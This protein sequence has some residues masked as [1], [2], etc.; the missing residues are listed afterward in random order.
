MN[1]KFS[2]KKMNRLLIGFLSILLIES[3]KIS[4]RGAYMIGYF[5]GFMEEAVWDEY[6]NVWTI[7]YGHTG[8]DVY[9]GQ[10][11]TREEALKLLQ[12]D[13][14]Y[15]ESFVNDKD[16]VPQTLNQAQFD[17]LVSFSYNL[18]PYT[19]PELC[20]GN[21]IEQIAVDIL[22][23]C[24][25]GGVE[26]PGLVKRRKAES[27]LLLYGYTGIS[28]IDEKYDGNPI[29]PP[30]NVK[31]TYTVMTKGG[32]FE[33][34]QDGEVAGKE[35]QKIIGIA[36]K[37][38]SG[39]VK[40]RVHIVGGSWLPY[41]TGYD[42]EDYDNGYAGNGKPI[43]CVEVIHDSIT[44]KYRVSPMNSDFYSWQK[45]SETGGDMD[46]YA[47]SYGKAIDHFQLTSA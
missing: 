7:G 29:A 34:I 3:M 2:Y 17:A 26:L 33:N 27:N 21:T 15:L 38:S 39:V 22:Q 30:T 23:Y 11:I 13:V 24:H 41:V 12:K 36:I 46:G 47:G 9:E 37:A 19:L 44:T 18:G 4:E 25:A 14:E 20:Q 32:N 16:F 43:D 6:G 31:F 10:T 42:L 1:L 8:E 35:G 40:Y 45:G 28:D 5:E